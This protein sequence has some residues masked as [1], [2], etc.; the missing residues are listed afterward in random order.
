MVAYF[1]RFSITMTLKLAASCSHRGECYDDVMAALE[2]PVIRR[3]LA[4]IDN[5]TLAAEL[6]EYGAWNEAELSD[7]A[8]NDARIIWIAAGDIRENLRAEV[9]DPTLIRVY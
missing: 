9:N 3:Q 6:K 1:N 5:A 7:R 8:Q 4:K 2:L